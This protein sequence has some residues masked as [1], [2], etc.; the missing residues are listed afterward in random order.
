M[1]LD[2]HYTDKFNTTKDEL[3]LFLE[4]T[5]CGSHWDLPDG[6]LAR[7]PQKLLWNISNQYFID[8]FTKLF[9]R[10]PKKPTDPKV[11][12][13][14]LEKIDCQIVKS[15]LLQYV[16]KKPVFEINE[17]V[18]IENKFIYFFDKTN[19]AYFKIRVRQRKGVG[20][21]YADN[22]TDLNNEHKEILHAWIDTHPFNAAYTLESIR[23][24]V[25]RNRKICNPEQKSMKPG[26]IVGRMSE[27]LRRGIVKKNKTGSKWWI[28]EK[29]IAE[30]A[31]ES[32]KFPEIKNV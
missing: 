29:E 31:L 21:G 6:N 1:S 32:G 10:T 8:V 4:K 27:L 23:F 14:E 11:Q 7:D 19:D 24:T 17:P 28:L 13:S 20:T 12:S 26:S 2:K 18:F 5:K 25:N 22:L 15:E 16:D 30:K 3:W 9:G